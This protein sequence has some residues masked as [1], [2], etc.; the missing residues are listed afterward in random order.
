MK[1]IAGRRNR[2]SAGTS[3]TTKSAVFAFI[4]IHLGLKKHFYCQP[5]SSQIRAKAATGSIAAVIGRPIT[6]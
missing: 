4:G 6:R 1:N 3:D 5:N 2:V